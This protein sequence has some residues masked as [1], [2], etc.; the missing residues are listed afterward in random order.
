MFHTA[1]LNFLASF[2]SGSLFK[3]R[4]LLFLLGAVFLQLSLVT[5]T[6][7]DFTW[8]WTILNVVD[9][10]LGY[11]AG[12]FARGALER[13]GYLVPGAGTGAR[14]PADQ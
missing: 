14:W 5:I 9:V 6:R 12:L 11:F 4:A 13:F 2:M 10:Q 1:I 3:I 7:G 8:E